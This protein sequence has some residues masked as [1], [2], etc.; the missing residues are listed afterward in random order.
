[1]LVDLIS[2][3]TKRGDLKSPLFLFIIQLKKVTSNHLSHK[4]LKY[5]KLLVIICQSI[6]DFLLIYLYLYGIIYI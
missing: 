5:F 3:V 2:E 6:F 4:K 1:M